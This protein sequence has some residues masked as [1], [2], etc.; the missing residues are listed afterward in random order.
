MKDDTLKRV[1]IEAKDIL[2]EFDRICKKNNLKYQMFAGSLLGTVRHKGFIPWDDDI[3]VC[4]LRED[5]E[6]FKA[7]C[8][9]DLKDNYF[10]QSYETDPEF[11][12]QFIKLRK[13]GTIFLEDNFKDSK[14]HHGIFIDIFALDNVRPNSILGLIQQKILYIMGR[15][16][17]L[18]VKR[19]SE[20]QDNK[21]K[22]SVFVFAHYILKAIP[23][24]WTDKL[25]TKVARMFNSEN[26]KYVSHLQNGVSKKRYNKFL[27]RK[28]EFNLTELAEF[29]GI[30]VPI[31]KNYKEVLENIYG[32]YMDLPNIEDRKPH[33]GVIK[34]EFN[35]KDRKEII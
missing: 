7:K 9:D 16:Q 32:N 22:R 10:F 25:D 12:R 20:K 18:R 26:E 15:L 1:Q 30:M 11:N 6:I 33:H 5:F 35:N 2:I 14:I 34:I 3:D 28:D 29:E 23:K 31:P 27:R 17:L 4:M 21:V 19:F 13:N 8:Q 24:K